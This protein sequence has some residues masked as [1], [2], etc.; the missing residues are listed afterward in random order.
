MNHLLLGGAGFV[1]SHLAH[2]L[3]N[4]G[5]QVT[6]LDSRLRATGIPLPDSVP[7]ILA[8]VRRLGEECPEIIGTSWDVVVNL[9]SVVGVP[10]VEAAPWDTLQTGWSAT[11]LALSLKTTRH[12]LASTSELYGPECPVTSE[13]SPV[14]I[15]DLRAPRAAYAVSKAWAET[16]LLTSG[17]DYVIVRFHNVYGPAMG[18][19]HVIPKFCQQLRGS[20]PVTVDDAT[21]VRAF[22]YIDDA[23]DGLLR[24]MTLSRAIVNIGNPENYLGK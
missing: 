2:A 7:L 12:V 18:M 20:G 21:A 13:T 9:A 8:D 3:V 24:A 1:G 4:A 14:V 6:V 19:D 5:H 23:V 17:Y 15:P 10:N 11:M 22:C 16:M